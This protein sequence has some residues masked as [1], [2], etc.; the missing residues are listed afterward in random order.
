MPGLRARV[1]WLAALTARPN[2]DAPDPSAD[3]PDPPDAET[4]PGAALAAPLGVVGGPKLARAIVLAVLCSY[5]AVQVI[6][7]LTSPI[8]ARL[9]LLTLDFTCL[10][11]LFALT[12][13]VTSAAVERWSHRRRLAVLLVQGFVTYLPMLVLLRE[14]GD[15]AGFFAGSVLL[16]LSGWLAWIMFAAAVGSMLIIPVAAHFSPYDTAYLVLSTLVLGLVVFGL[17]RLSLLVKYTYATRGELAQLAVL[18]ERTRFARDLHD[19]LGYSLSAITLKAELTRR[20][21]GSNPARARDELAEVID[22]AR[23]AQADTRLVAS[24]Y[25]NIS[26]AKEASLVAALLATAGIEG[27]PEISCGALDEATD[28]VLATVV[29]EAVTNML[30]HSTARTYSIE[31]AQVGE[32][33]RLRVVNDGVPE[34]PPSGTHR[35][36]IENLTARCEAIGGRLTTKVHDDQFCLVAEAPNQGMGVARKDSGALHAGAEDPARRGRRDGPR[37]SRGPHRTRA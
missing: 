2:A 16:L 33:V 3:A 1:G 21:V 27:R 11:L 25:R 9:D 23:Q 28:T 8:P 19:L 13:F 6:D 29:R 20:L 26:L 4:E 17:A 36:G 24:G 30:R 10:L 31:A 15:M 14:W 35:G 22:I 12:A 7:A 37:R 5:L 18:K 34:P 32:I